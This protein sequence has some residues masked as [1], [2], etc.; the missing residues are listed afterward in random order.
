MALDPN[1]ILQA[2]GVQLDS[3]LDT[4]ARV[5]QV[6]AARNQNR[7]A[8]LAFADKARATAADA[9]LAQ[10]LS[11][12]S[13]G[14]DVVKG[15]A[16]QGYGSQALAYQKSNQESL[17][18]QADIAKT[19]A[20]TVAKQQ[21]QAQHQ[22][23]IAGQLAG[24]WATNPGISKPMIM[25]GI[26]AA[27]NSGVLTPQVAQ[28]QLAE[29]EKVGDDPKSLNGWAATKQQQVISAKDQM[30]NA[31]TQQR[32][33]EVR[34]ANGAREANAAGMLGVARGNLGVAQQ[35]LSLDQSTP[36]GQVVQTDEGPVLV[37]PRTGTGKAVTGPD[38]QRLAGTAK[39]LNEGQS[40]AL[41]FGTR[42]QEANRVLADLEKDGV[43]AS[44]PGSRAAYVGGA[45]NA[46]TTGNNQALNQAKTDFLAAVLRRESGA[47]IGAS[48]Y[49]NGDKQYFPQVGDTPKVIAQKA[50]NRELAI[51]GVLAEVPEKARKSITPTQNPFEQAPA[52]A[53]KSSAQASKAAPAKNAKGWTLETD[54]N[55]NRAY[56]SPDRKSYEEIK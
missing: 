2:R 6:Q 53:A 45:I 31:L 18:S 22:F 25:A 41:L 56:V 14:A 27:A 40:K 17:K 51:N 23:E 43:S 26:N 19:Q 33:A 7:I 20:D 37:D 1:I 35:R 38:G 34:R 42:M 44:V 24:S 21:E 54:A 32:D 48:E 39:A 49:D 10:L 13:S 12:G 4:Y 15:L 30:T 11:S 28:A 8:D 47:A 9:S 50:R 3:P 36:R 16:G 5:A 55:G 46:L 52:A 29:L